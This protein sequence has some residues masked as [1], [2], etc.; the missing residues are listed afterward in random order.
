MRTISH[1]AR[2]HAVGTRRY[3]GYQLAAHL[4]GYS[5]QATNAA[6]PPLRVSGYAARLG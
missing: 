1:G 5:R 4:P 2:C 3:R 6:R